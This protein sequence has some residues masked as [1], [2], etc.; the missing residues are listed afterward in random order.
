MPRIPGEL[1]AKRTSQK[2]GLRSK[3]HK[4]AVYTPPLQLTW[5]KKN[6][7]FCTSFVSSLHLSS[8]PCHVRAIEDATFRNQ[9]CQIGA[10][11]G[12]VK[13]QHCFF[14][15]CIHLLQVA[16]FY[17]SYP[18]QS[19][20]VKKWRHSQL[21]LEKIKISMLINKCP[22]FPGNSW[23]KELAKKKGLRSKEHK[24][25]VYPSHCN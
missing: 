2:K 15:G 13:T 16:N 6:T 23:Q 24:F 10:Y 25:A 14:F 22:G 1:V 20:V 9:W 3:E 18:F 12:S 21:Y 19:L 8:H 17:A 7:C 4:F 5:K 11:H